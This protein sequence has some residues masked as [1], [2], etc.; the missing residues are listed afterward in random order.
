[1]SGFLDLCGHYMVH[2]YSPFVLSMVRV[3][4]VSLTRWYLSWLHVTDDIRVRDNV[5]TIMQHIIQC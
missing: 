5:T 2:I 4:D 3:C 1:M